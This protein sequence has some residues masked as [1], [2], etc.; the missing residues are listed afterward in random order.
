MLFLVEYPQY[1]SKAGA[2]MR[3]AYQSALKSILH[4]DI[5]R[6]RDSMGLTQN[7]MAELLMMDVRSYVE[8]DHGNSLVGTLSFVLFLIN[9]CQDP[10]K[11]LENI[12]EAFDK[13]G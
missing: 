10:S 4:D 1:Y 13:M 8:I 7:Q 2:A 11:L 6:T 12:H 9:C 5:I 3:R